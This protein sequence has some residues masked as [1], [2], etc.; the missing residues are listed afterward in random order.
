MRKTRRGDPTVLLLNVDAHR[1]QW[2]LPDGA[3]DAIAAR[4]PRLT[5]VRVQDARALRE[6]LP[7]AEVLYTWQLPRELFVLARRLRWVHTPA[8]G[9]DHL[10]HAAFRSSD[11]LLSNSRGV[12]GDAMADHV[13]AMMLALARRL[14]ESVRFQD[15]LRWGQD[16][17]WSKTP[18]PFALTGRTLGI[19]GLGG[20]G[21]E[22]ARRARAFGMKVH[23]IKRSQGRAPSSV[24]KLYE[25]EQLLDLLA[26][27]DFV[28]CAA[29]LTPETRSLMGAREFRHMKPTGYF[30]NVGRGEQVE[31]GALIRA[32]R[33]GQIAG[34]AL[35]VFRREPLPK[36]SVLWRVPNLLITPHYAGTYP[37][38]MARATDLFIENLALYLSGRSSRLKNLV[39]KRRGY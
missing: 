22:L 29:P 8:A 7:R 4:F 9:V 5:I 24:A 28:V 35:D 23:A 25:P 26:E 3:Q 33:E 32:L 20:V 30:I 12:A 10:L 15:Q 39:D 14:P 19:L 21:I 16:A 27:S 17:F 31:E 11:V 36:N 2:S 1:K 38:H 6:E 37:E 18:I 13:F 34:A